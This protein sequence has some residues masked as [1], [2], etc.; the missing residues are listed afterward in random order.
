MSR[1][2]ELD[3]ADR[4]RSLTEADVDDLWR[5]IRRERIAAHPSQTPEAKR[6][7]YQRCK[8]TVNARKRARYANDPEYRQRASLTAKAAYQRR[9]SR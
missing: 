7:R 5:A 8:A 2:D 4:E 3:A 6:V 9:K 1:L